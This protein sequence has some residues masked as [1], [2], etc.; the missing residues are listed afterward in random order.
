MKVCPRK[1]LTG[2][3]IHK[4]YTLSDRQID[5]NVRHTDGV[6]D[7]I[8]NLKEITEELTCLLDIQIFTVKILMKNEGLYTE[9]TETAHI[10][11]LAECLTLSHLKNCFHT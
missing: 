10:G 11:T 9:N 4:F 1:L 5:H 3:R 7:L 8:T 2:P 6:C